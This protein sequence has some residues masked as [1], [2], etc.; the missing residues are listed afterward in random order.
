MECTAGDRAHPAIILSRMGRPALRT[1]AAGV[2]AATMVVAASGCASWRTESGEKVVTG[3]RPPWRPATMTAREA[4]AA[5]VGVVAPMNCAVARHYALES[6]LMGGRGRISVRRIARLRPTLLE[7]SRQRRA[8][9]E[10]LLRHDWPEDVW[11]HVE[12]LVHLWDALSQ[13]EGS[14]PPDPTVSDWNNVTGRI[15]ALF[16]DRTGTLVAT[17][18]AGLG[19]PE[20][21]STAEDTLGCL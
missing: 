20:A 2:L 17:V 5:Y 8:A 21:P 12:A 13:A 11:P 6:E 16:D 1:I 14:L 3:A 19:L 18:R 15:D 7:M 10:A 4:R 9:A